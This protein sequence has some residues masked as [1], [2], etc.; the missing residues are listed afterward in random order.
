MCCL[1]VRL[2]CYSMPEIPYKYFMSVSPLDGKLY[3]SDHHGL[4]IIR[5]KTMGGVRDLTQNFEVIAGTG[6]QCMPGDLERCGDGGLAIASR[7]HYPKGECLIVVFRA[8]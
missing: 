6:D 2:S 5:V 7:L 4:R 3:I 8:G 1:N